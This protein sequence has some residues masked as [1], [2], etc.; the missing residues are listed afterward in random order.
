VEWR[1]EGVLSMSSLTSASAGG[2]AVALL[3]SVAVAMLVWAFIDR[4][5]SKE[6]PDDSPSDLP[7][8]QQ[9]DAD[10]GNLNQD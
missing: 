8:Q 10:A 3:L 5:R 9:T 4:R 2:F 6:P 7:D 1:M